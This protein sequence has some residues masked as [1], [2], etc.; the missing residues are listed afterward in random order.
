MPAP[1]TAATRH[2]QPLALCL[3]VAAAWMASAAAPQALAAPPTAVLRHSAPALQAT[4]GP[5]PLAQ[6]DGRW[7]APQGGHWPVWRLT[8]SSGAHEAG[9]TTWQLPAPPTAGQPAQDTPDAWD[10]W[11]ALPA[12]SGAALAVW[13]TPVGPLAVPQGWTVRQAG[14]GA[15]GSFQLVFAPPDATGRDRPYLWLRHTGTCAGCAYAEASLYFPEARPLARQ[16]EVPVWQA[17][18]RLL[19]SRSQTGPARCLDYRWPVP[20]PTPVLGVACF[21]PRQ[22]EAFQD[23]RLRLPGGQAALARALL[24]QP[25][26]TLAADVP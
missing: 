4:Q 2:R 23:L 17:R 25:A 9:V 18:P 6:A 26:A 10:A 15:N 1:L 13:A 21:D 11:R 19:L 22:G 14:L 24:R 8:V 20:G 5:A 3:A 12:V 16:A 7:P